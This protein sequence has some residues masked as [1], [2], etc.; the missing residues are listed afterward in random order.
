MKFFD[1]PPFVSVKDV[2][3][4]PIVLELELPWNSRLLAT[5]PVSVM[6]CGRALP[7]VILIASPLKENVIGVVPVACERVSMADV[8]PPRGL[9]RAVADRIFS[10]I[11]FSVMRALRSTDDISSRRFFSLIVRMVAVTRKVVSVI[12]TPQ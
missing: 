11:I 7:A 3:M 2:R 1:V 12:A 5:T 6:R 4:N 8:A 9:C 10:V